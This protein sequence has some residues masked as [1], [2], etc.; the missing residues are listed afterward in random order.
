MKTRTKRL[1]LKALALVAL[2]LG[3]FGLTLLS[4]QLP[5]VANLEERTVD[6]RLRFRLPDP[7]FGQDILVVLLDDEALEPYPYRSP[8]PR[9]LLAALIEIVS[10]SGAGL[11]GL[12]V[13]L[14]DLTWPQKDMALVQAMHRSGRVVL[15]STLVQAESQLKLDLPQTKFLEAALALGLADLPVDPVDQAV[16]RVKIAYQ[17]GDREVPALSVALFLA[18]AQSGTDLPKIP[19]PRAFQAARPKLKLDGRGSFPINYQAPPSSAGQGQNLI[20]AL[21]ASA[22]LSGLLPQDWFKDK[23]VLIG[24]GY[25]DSTDSFRT[26]FYSRRY[27]FALTPGVEIH[28]NALATILQG[29]S[30]FPLAPGWTWVLLLGLAALTLPLEWRFKPVVTAAFLIGAGLLYSAA[31]FLVFDKT[32]LILPL[33]PAFLI[34]GLT[35]VSAVTLRSLTEGRQRR[36]INEAFGRYVSPQLVEILVKNPDQLELGGVE[37]EL[38][39]MFT[40]LEGFTPMAESLSPRELVKRLNTYLDGMTQVL[41]KHGGTLDKYEGDALV[42]F[43]NAP[44]ERQDHAAAAAACALEMVDYSR[45]LSRS[46]EQEGRPPFKTRIGLNSGRVIVGN[47]GSSRRFNYTVIGDEANLA[48]RL[49]SAN[50]SFGT[51]V[52]ISQATSDRLNDR[53]RVRRLGG[54]LV[55]GKTKPIMV[56]ELLDRPDPDQDENVAVM[57]ELYHNGIEAFGRRDFDRAARFFEEALSVKDNDGPS[58]TYV[59]RCRFLKDNPPGDDWDGVLTLDEK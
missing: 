18:L 49:E 42:A 17:V 50:K 47:I 36:W 14:K 44:L 12:D 41:L 38:T 31:G 30:I 29:R 27:G 9:D 58:Q 25:S 51:Q 45:R 23:I 19:D 48:A 56:F 26:P 15:V 4:G 16:R 8:V 52:M 43:W 21:P 37:R 32:G 1:I 46:L 40:D 35:F 3:S 5:M 11:I 33:V 2:A 13:F 57:L 10:R 54:L 53:F 24:A 28:A 59:R 20:K 39:V 6:L 7:K 34:L 55:K 22:V